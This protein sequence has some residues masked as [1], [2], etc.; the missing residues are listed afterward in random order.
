MRLHLLHPLG[1][2]ALLVVFVPVEIAHAQGSRPG[3]RPPEYAIVDCPTITIEPVALPRSELCV[4]YSTALTASGGKPPYS[5]VVVGGSLPTGLH[6]LSSGHLSGVPSEAGASAFS[7]RVIDGYGCR[8]QRDF[9]LP[10]TIGHRASDGQVGLAL[11]PAG[12]GGS[13]IPSQDT[14]VSI[15]TI[16]G[17]PTYVAPTGIAVHLTLVHQRMGD[18][19]LTL[20]TPTGRRVTL[21]AERGGSGSSYFGTKFDDRA[22]TP[23]CSGLAPF[24]AEYRPETPIGACGMAG[25]WTLEIEDGVSG[26]VGWLF[27]WSI[28]FTTARTGFNNPSGLPFGQ[29]TAAAPLA[30]QG[31][32]Q[33]SENVYYSA[34]SFVAARP[35]ADFTGPGSWSRDMTPAVPLQLLTAESSM[36][37]DHFVFIDSSGFVYDVNRS[38]GVTVWSRNLRRASCSSDTLSAAPVAQIWERSNCDFQTAIPS[39]DLLYVGTDFAC[40]NTTANRV[41]ALDLATGA[42]RWIFNSTATYSVD[43]VT[44][45]ALDDTN[46]LLIVTTDE[47]VP[48]ANQPTIMAV[49][50]LNGARAWARDLGAILS[51]PIVSSRGVYVLEASGVLHRVDPMTGVDGWTFPLT[52]LSGYDN[53]MAYDSSRDLIFLAGPDG[54]LHAIHDDGAS[55]SILW[56][57]G[58]PLFQGP[59]VVAPFT[60]KV[61]ASGDLN[62]VRQLAELTGVIESYATEF[63]GFPILDLLLDTT[64]GGGLVDARIVTQAQGHVVRLAVPW[65]NPGEHGGVGGGTE[66][67]VE[68]YVDLGIQGST[69]PPSPGVGDVL[70]D[71]LTVTNHGIAST[72][73]VEV[74]TP[75][76][77]RTVF[78]GGTA[79]HG[80]VRL[81]GDTI[82]ARAGALEIGQTATIVVTLQLVVAGAHPRT[83]AVSSPELPDPWPANDAVTLN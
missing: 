75:V 1:L 58:P 9:V 54:I 25:T 15:L 60:Q 18:L 82:V 64:I 42:T 17:V 13:G 46:N 63:S 79:S 34:G 80:T 57:Q 19:T 22:T 4:D 12:S 77:A 38:S 76:P 11:P 27:D 31:C 65:I 20:V 51:K 36:G 2:L 29:A 83:H 23:V 37:L 16:G 81:E 28:D 48:G 72:H 43:R 32:A 24:D 62:R 59:V 56:N 70:T 14:A 44:G 71:T 5:F 47:S 40:G 68:P 7:V 3:I 30:N 45:L 55:A 35:K 52:A 26:S 66:S 69:S 49:N 53:E 67:P 74:R 78:L 10:V 6:L 33:D 41:H 73:C 61:Y 50:T 21:A 8:G 39:L